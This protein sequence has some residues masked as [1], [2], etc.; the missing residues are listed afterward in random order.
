MGQLAAISTVGT[1]YDGPFVIE[2]EHATQIVSNLS[3]ER[4]YESDGKLIMA[5]WIIQMFFCCC[6]CCFGSYAAKSPGQALQGGGTQGYSEL[7]QK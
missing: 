5:L 4:T 7:D 6:Q 3:N 2:S 1:K